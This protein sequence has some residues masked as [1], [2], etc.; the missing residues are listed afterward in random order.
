[1]T[2]DAPTKSLRRGARLAIINALA[3]ASIAFASSASAAP[4]AF[5]VHKNG[6]D[7]TI[8]ASTNTMLTWSTE[9]FDTNDNFSSNRFTPTAAGKYLIVVSARC[10][11]P[12]MCIPS[13]YK[14]GT[15]YAQTQW[16]NHNFADQ[17]PQATAIIDMNGSGDYV[18]AYV[19]S[20]GT[21]IGGTAERTYFS[22]SQ[23]D[24][25]GSGGSGAGANTMVSGLPDAIRCIESGHFRILYSQVAPNSA[26][27]VLYRS[28]DSSFSINHQI[29]FTTAG[30][31]QSHSS[32]AGSDCLN[33]SIAQLYAA[34]QAFNFVG[35][36]S[37]A[38]AGN[39][40]QIQFNEGG[41][42]QADAGLHW[43]NTNKRLGI[44]T[45]T[46]DQG[47]SVHG[48]VSTRG[49]DGFRVGGVSSAY[50]GSLVNDGSGIL[51]LVGDAGRNIKLAPGGTEA[52]RIAA[53]GNVG[54]GSAAPASR[55]VVTHSG[56]LGYADTTLVSDAPNLAAGSGYSAR[57]RGFSGADHV[58]I[59]N[60][61]NVGIGT[62]EPTQKLHVVGNLR[63][64]GAMWSNGFTSSA[65]GASGVWR[66][67][68][69]D[70]TGDIR[71]PPNGVV[72]HQDGV[73]TRFAIAQDGNVGIGTA[74][75]A[76]LLH[77][78]GGS[79][80]LRLAPSAG[81]STALAMYD[82][83]GNAAARGWGW[84]TNDTTW[85][86][87][88][89]YESAASTSD[90]FAGAARM[91]I[92]SGGSV[93]IGTTAPSHILHI[94]GQGRSTVASWA[95]S[96]DARVKEDIH[97]I[98]GGLEAIDK[99]RPVTFRY[100]DEYQNGNPALGGM[101]R[102]FIAQEVETVLPD[103]V[104]RSVEKVGNREI[105][106]FRVLGNSDFVPLLV[107]AVKELKAA[108][109]NLRAANDDLRS[110]LRDT[111]NSQDAQIEA[112]RRKIEAL[113]ITR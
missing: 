46:P 44:G 51:T 64:S 21:V 112:L 35:G 28:R 24:G 11:Q 86:N 52:M 98:N 75:P 96:S 14:N 72:I 79:E 1:M 29:T 110:E 5:S 53:N 36:A 92:L 85:G 23:I 38:A 69:C 76:T 70:G 56:N 87:L 3:W 83:G 67:S 99:L 13:I 7:Q 74:S 60:D 59:R 62:T 91:T 18:E 111:I 20:T 105:S 47:L 66:F 12:G 103:V 104:T 34:D 108:N 97:T 90:P 42:L 102:G 109:D 2:L 78:S 57:F 107:S 43:D 65:T 50:I 26:G 73:N 31:Y 54:I 16:T 6:T 9:V 32:M 63:A 88:R 89:L 19:Y 22:G 39:A 77:V 82:G 55:L 101:R 93:G 81:N 80:Q 71:C 58:V 40:G 15:L 37:A 25:I 48:A 68:A 61:G 84:R 95:T 30:E 41:N 27:I 8:S 100:T 94:T 33:K 10:A 4:P 106:D 45:T 49:S 113:E 17:S